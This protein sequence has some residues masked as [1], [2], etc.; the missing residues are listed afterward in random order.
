[1]EMKQSYAVKENL[2]KSARATSKELILL[3]VFDRKIICL[4]T[5]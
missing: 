5:A 1:M 2:N 4:T 3:R